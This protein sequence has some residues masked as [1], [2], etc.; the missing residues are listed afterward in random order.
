MAACCPAN[1]L[2]VD[3]FCRVI[4]NF[5]DIGVCWRLARQLYG[6]AT[7]PQI[8]LWV[9]DLHSFAKIEPGVSPEARTQTVGG[10]ELIHWTDTPP[11]L[12]PHPIVIEAFACDPPPAFIA[13]MVQQQSLWINL[14]YLSAEAWVE[15]CHARPSLQ[16]NGLKKSFFFPGFT[17]G[18]GGLLREHDLIVRRDRW[19]SQPEWR[20]QMLSQ[21][22]VAPELIEGLQ[23]GWRQVFLFCYPSAP[24][25]ALVQTLGR[26]T[27]PS[28]I[29]AP[30]GIQPQL[31]HHAAA[32]ESPN[33]HVVEIP[34][35]DQNT[36]DQLLWSS[37][38]NFVR[39]EDSL[40]RA[41]W[42]AK[43]LVWQIYEQDEQAHL[44]KLM[45]WLDRSPFTPAVHKFMIS[46]NTADEAAFGLE[47]QQALQPA[48]F[49]RWQADAAQWS[50][51]LAARR[52]LIQ[53][54]LEFCAKNQRTG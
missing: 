54:L 13:R 47:L 1:S 21:L 26:Q 9:D 7:Q 27:T 14:E 19:H 42:A 40:V 33:V 37:D 28:V 2:S 32:P 18:T 25:N 46:W 44:D 23:Q 6:S 48:A 51:E 24:A 45:A 10:I 34:F 38:L 8:R 12:T 22:G 30:S 31:N 4:D 15:S 36:F 53:S 5:G 35:V 3:I 20:W 41:L 43:P 29:L 50:R 16:S 39:G 11:A 49:E 52:S 17:S